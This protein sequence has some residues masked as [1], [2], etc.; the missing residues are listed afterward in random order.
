MTIVKDFEDAAKESSQEAITIR[1]LRTRGRYYYVQHS[2]QHEENLCKVPKQKSE[3]LAKGVYKS[4]IN[5]LLVAFPRLLHLSKNL[6][7]KLR[8]IRL[9]L[10]SDSFSKQK[11]NLGLFL[12]VSITNGIQN[13]MKLI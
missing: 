6:E 1:K 5:K 13:K 10:P 9:D 8:S 12:K 2:T 3:Y 11:L 4:R 7:A